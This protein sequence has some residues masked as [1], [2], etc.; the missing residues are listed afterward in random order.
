MP[1]FSTKRRV[2][3]AATEM[4]ELVADVDKY[5]QFVPL[6]SALAVKTALRGARASLFW[7]RI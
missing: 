5:P 2:R 1:H 7:S 4:F 3:H 6:C